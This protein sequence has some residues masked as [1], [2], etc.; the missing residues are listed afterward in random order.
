MTKDPIKKFFAL[1]YSS[2]AA[3][4][5]FGAPGNLGNLAFATL[6]IATALALLRRG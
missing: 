1:L 5:L 3:V 6:F 4:L 2:I